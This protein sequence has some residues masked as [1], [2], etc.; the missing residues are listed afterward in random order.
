MDEAIIEKL[1][2]VAPQFGFLVLFV[3]ALALLLK[4]YRTLRTDMKQSV[5]DAVNARLGSLM[6]NLQ[7]ETS[8]AAQLLNE[9]KATQKETQDFSQSFQHDLLGRAN[10]INQTFTAVERKLAVLQK[11]VPKEGELKYSAREFA[12][13]ASHVT[14]LAEAMDLLGQAQ[15]DTDATSKDME[16]A[17]DVAR[18]FR[19]FSLALDFYRK[20]TEMDPDNLSAK[21]EL[22]ALLA[23]TDAKKRG[24]YLAQLTE[25]VL[26]S[27]QPKIQMRVANTLLELDRYDDLAGMCESIIEAEGDKSSPLLAQAHRDLAVCHRQKRNFTQAE[28]HFK[29]AL[30]I[31]PDDENLIKAFI[32]LLR[33]TKEHDQALA[34]AKK[35]VTLD[36]LDWHYH[37]ILAREHVD[38]EQ[39]DTAIHWFDRALPLVPSAAEQQAVQREKQKV[40][41]L[42]E[43]KEQDD[44][45]PN[46]ALEATLASAPQG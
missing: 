45:S 28:E 3:V 31:T 36:A 2:E 17:G 42:Q 26:R 7:I 21:T 22:L 41:L 33:D 35:L 46:K 44:I 29:T 5:D 14:S 10:E 16:V 40:V 11:S 13:L 12:A 4:E 20:A 15:Q 24:E 39:Y 38:L 23:E 32:G 19:R 43:F 25:T 30:S 9:M 8:K 34:L 37:V 18:K 6:G 1:F 27:M